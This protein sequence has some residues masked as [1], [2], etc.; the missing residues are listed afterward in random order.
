MNVRRNNERETRLPT[1]PETV[2]LAEQGLAAY[3]RAVAA[4]LGV[5]EDATSYE[6]SDTANAYLALTRRSPH[7]PDGDLML[8]WNDEDG[9]HAALEAAPAR[10]STVIAYLGGDNVVP[11]PQVVATFVDDL[12]AGRR[13]GT[14]TPPDSR[15]SEP[16]LIAD[17][18]ARY[19]E[20]RE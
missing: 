7:H 12:L 15:S 10:P 8:I 2:P 1:K 9:W 4:L 14:L 16:R 3:V 13:A 20:P 17:R 5:P 19:G 18:L 6:V 11:E